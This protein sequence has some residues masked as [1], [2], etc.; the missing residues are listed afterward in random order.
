MNLLVVVFQVVNILII[1]ALICCQ[2]LRVLRSRKYGCYWSLVRLIFYKDPRGIKW[3]LN[4]PMYLFNQIFLVSL[5][6]LEIT[7]TGQ[8]MNHELLDGLLIKIFS[9]MAWLCVL[10]YF[11]IIDVN[12]DPEESK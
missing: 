3:M 1:F 12:K 4:N 9:P 5:I 10:Y 2:L 11:M 7:F 6:L 8:L